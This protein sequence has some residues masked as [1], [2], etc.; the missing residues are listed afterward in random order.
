MKTIAILAAI[1]LVSCHFTGCAGINSLSFD[2]PWASGSKDADGNITI[3]PK[4]TTII[5]PTK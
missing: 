2:T 1:A 4:A 5:I 3:V